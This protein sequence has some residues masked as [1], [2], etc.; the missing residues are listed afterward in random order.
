MTD[1]QQQAQEARHA[2]QEAI[3][4]RDN[5]GEYGRQDLSVASR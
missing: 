1:E 2:L 3:D 4:R 5:G